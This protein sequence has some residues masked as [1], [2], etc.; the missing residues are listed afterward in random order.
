MIVLSVVLETFGFTDY[1]IYYNGD[2]D[3]FHHIP[4]PHLDDLTVLLQKNIASVLSIMRSIGREPAYNIIFHSGPGCEFYIEIL[5]Y[6]QETGGYE[7][8]GLFVC[9]GSPGSTAE[10]YMNAGEFL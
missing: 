3:Y 4:L 10:M 5:P 1:N 9:Q 8:L 7:H 2:A 6:T